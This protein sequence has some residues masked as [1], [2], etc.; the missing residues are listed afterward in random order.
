MNKESINKYKIIVSSSET[1][2][3]VCK[4]HIRPGGEC[5][6]CGWSDLRPVDIS[7]R[8]WNRASTKAVS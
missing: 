8:Q 2:C 4:Y 5:R 3:P 1:S 6:R 7:W